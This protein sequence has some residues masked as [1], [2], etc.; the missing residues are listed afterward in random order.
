MAVFLKWE[1]RP[2]VQIAGLVTGRH[3]RGDGGRQ[4]AGPMWGPGRFR[5]QSKLSRVGQVASVTG[6]TKGSPE[7]SSVSQVVGQ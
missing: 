3:C 5:K 2:E 4:E 7:E 1:A 6:N